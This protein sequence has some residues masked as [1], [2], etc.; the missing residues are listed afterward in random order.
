[1]KSNTLSLSQSSFE[2]EEI[3]VIN[4]DVKLNSNLGLIEA[5]ERSEKP[6]KKSKKIHK[7][8]KK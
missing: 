1:M 6:D 7:K 3:P 4:F 8:S 2:D 5:A